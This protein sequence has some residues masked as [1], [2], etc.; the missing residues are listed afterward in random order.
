MTPEDVAMTLR[1]LADAADDLRVCRERLAELPL[2]TSKRYGLGAASPGKARKDILF[3][4]AE[5]EAKIRVALT[6]EEIEWV[7]STTNGKR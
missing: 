1:H 6:P 5:A 2:P 3:H 7:L 4:M